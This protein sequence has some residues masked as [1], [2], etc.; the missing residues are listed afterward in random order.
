LQPAGAA[1]RT[2]KNQQQLGQQHV[3]SERTGQPYDTASAGLAG[4]VPPQHP[5]ITQPLQHHQQGFSITGPSINPGTLLG[6]S[7]TQQG[8]ITPVN[9]S[10]AVL[11]QLAA[12]QQ[13][14]QSQRQGLTAGAV[15]LPT[16]T[17]GRVPV[18]GHQKNP[19]NLVVAGNIASE[20]NLSSGV[21]TTAAGLTRTPQLDL[22]RLQAALV[23]H[24]PGPPRLQALQVSFSYVV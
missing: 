23:N 10:P 14:V 8:S 5:I 2:F 18:P 17:P 12:I 11:A 19:S 22:A 24:A 4:T 9:L 3:T 6:L 21:S 13:A 1:S 20:G 15:Q 7:V 16:L